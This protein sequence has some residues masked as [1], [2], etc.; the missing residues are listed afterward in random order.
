MYYAG[1]Q[2]HMAAITAGV[3]PRFGIGTGCL[4]VDT[5]HD[6]TILS[7]KPAPTLYDY[8]QK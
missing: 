8:K 2:G 3:P 1:L 4:A 6:K 7:Q 5:R